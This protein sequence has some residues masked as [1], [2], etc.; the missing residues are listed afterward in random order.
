MP[1]DPS[2]R[3]RAALQRNAT[4]AARLAFADFHFKVTNGNGFY[5]FPKAG[6]F[7]L[8]FAERPAVSTGVVIDIDALA[9]LE[10]VE[11]E[12]DIVVP[13]ITGFVV[14]WDLNE[15]GFYVGAWCGVNV[16]WPVGAVAPE[17]YV[18]YIDYTFHGIAIKDVDPEV[19]E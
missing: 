1:W 3:R 19:R 16:Y 8:T 9:E 15:R 4:N 14:E 12:D 11:D 5:Q 18:F 13:S 10:E 7:G 2:E 6:D 17:D